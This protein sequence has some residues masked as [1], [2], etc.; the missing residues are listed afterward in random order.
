MILNRLYLSRLVRPWI[1][2]EESLSGF[3]HA[4]SVSLCLVLQVVGVVAP[5]MMV[6][7]VACHEAGL[8]CVPPWYI[9]STAEELVPIVVVLV[10]VWCRCWLS[11]LSR[12]GRW[13]LCECQRPRVAATSSSTALTPP[14]PASS[15]SP[16]SWLRL[17]RYNGGSEEVWESC[18]SPS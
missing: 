6:F 13:M 10:R 17:L 7:L 18:R 3:P 5:F 4:R 14:P 15:V 16:A 8:A 2:W 11:L 1:G 12:S 9:K